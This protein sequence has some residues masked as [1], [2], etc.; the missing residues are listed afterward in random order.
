MYAIFLLVLLADV[1]RS[2]ATVPMAGD[3]AGGLMLAAS[4]LQPGPIA[5]N[6]MVS[7]RPER[8]F[9]SLAGLSDYWCSRAALTQP[10]IQAGRM[11]LVFP[12]A[13]SCAQKFQARPLPMPSRPTIPRWRFSRIPAVLPPKNPRL[14]AAL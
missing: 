11:A 1:A 14:D 7:S 12:M 2:H 9:P 3:A 5:G 4:Q 6:A 8:G 13:A 10:A